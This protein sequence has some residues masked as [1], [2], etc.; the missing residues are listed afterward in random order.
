MMNTSVPSNNRF[1]ALAPLVFL[2]ATA[3][4]NVKSGQAVEPASSTNAAE[5]YRQAFELVDGLDD[6]HAQA[7]GDPGTRNLRGRWVVT[8]RID[9]ETANLVERLDPAVDLVRTAAAE[10]EAQWPD[11]DGGH[12]IE[13]GNI[14]RTLSGL[15]VFKARHDLD[16][17]E[18][19]EA[20]ENLLG[21]LAVA[22]HASSVPNFLTKQI[23]NAASSLPVEALAQHL[24]SLPKELVAVLPERMKELPRSP[25]MAQVIR[26]EYEFAKSDSTKKGVF[27]EQIVGLKDFYST[28]ADD[29]QLAPDQFE[30]LVERLTEEYSNNALAR[31][32]GPVFPRMQNSVAI[33]ETRQAMLEVAIQVV[34]QGD[35]AVAALNEP[36]GNEPFGF[37]KL[38]EGFEL[39][40]N[41]ESR[42]EPV[43]LRFGR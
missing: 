38:S 1:R 18:F 5:L 41:L 32:L 33:A 9:H 28:L 43:K 29:A 21:A 7:L 8:T 15:L 11:I 27:A 34:L 30:D 40:S 35:S 31:T 10:S 4:W 39:R 26:G 23:E 20:I 2:M 42:G 19:E 12:L 36:Y 25:T 24:P 17:G 22:R 3:T 16:N 14:A 13:I 37:Q 6:T